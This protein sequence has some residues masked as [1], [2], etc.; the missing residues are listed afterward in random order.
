MIDRFFNILKVIEEF[1]FAVLFCIHAPT[2]SKCIK[3]YVK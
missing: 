1:G 3:C 2:I